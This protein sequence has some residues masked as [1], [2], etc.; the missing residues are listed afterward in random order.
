MEG[1]TANGARAERARAKGTMAERAGAEGARAV[2]YP[3]CQRLD[4]YMSPICFRGS[5]GGPSGGPRE[6]DF[7]FWGGKWVGNSKLV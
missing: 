6:L 1:E 4:E 3:T 7:G 5:A 2:A